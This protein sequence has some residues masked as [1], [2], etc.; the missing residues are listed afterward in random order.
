M[1]WLRRIGMRVRSIFGRHKLEAALDSELAFHMAE[2]KAEY[3]SRGMSE[4]EAERAVRLEFG[5]VTAMA[6][7]CRDQR[8]TRWLEDLTADTKYAI[9][10]LLHSPGFTWAA[11]ATL[12]LG[13]G[14]NVV[15]FS[16]AYGVL[17]RPLPYREPDRLVE[18]ELGMGGVG[19][20]TNL[21]SMAQ[22]ADYAGYSP[23]IE[24][25][26]RQNGEALRVET[27]T[28]TWNLSR[29]LGVP[30][31]LGRWFEPGEEH[32]NSPR[33][34]VLSDHTW[35]ERFA[36]DPAIIGRQ[37]LIDE[38]PHDVVGVMPPGFAFP[39]RE[40]AMWLPIRIDPA[41]RALMWSGP[42]LL[43]I[44]RLNQGVSLPSAQTELRLIVDRVRPLFPWRMPD[45][46][47]TSSTLVLHSQALVKDARP[48]LL[49]LAMA[50]FL[51]LIIACGN[52]ANLLLTRCVLRARE[53]AVR[54]ALGAGRGRLLR[55][56]AAENMVLVAAGAAAGL[57]ISLVL[58][59]ALPLALGQLPRLDEVTVAPVAAAAA[60]GI[61]LLT[62]A[63]LSV[64]P[65][66]RRRPSSR[67]SLVLAVFQLSLTTALLIG[68]SLLGRTLWQLASVDTGIHSHEILAASVSAG[69]SRCSSVE[70]CVAFLEEVSSTLVGVPGIHGVSWSNGIPLTQKHSAMSVAVQ[71]HPK[72][73]GEPAF[74]LWH[75]AATPGYFGALGIP[76]RAGRFFTA[77][78]RAGG[79]PVVVIS[80]S[81]AKKFWPNESPIGKSIRPVSG[82]VWRTVIGVA[83]DVMH[84]S[85]DG[86]PSWID[87]VQYVPH[88]Q[89]PP[90]SSSAFQQSVFLECAGIDA[91]LLQQSLRQRFPDVAITGL[92][93]LQGV[94]AASV[95][96]RRSTAWLMSLLAALALFLGIVGVY[97]TLSQRAEQRRPE[98][99]IRMALGARPI[100]IGGVVLRE[101][102][103]V[104]LVGS[105]IGVVAALGLTRFLRTLLFGISETDPIAYVAGPA[106]LVTTA[107][108][109]AALPALRASRLDP[110]KVLRSE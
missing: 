25:T 48:K 98:V 41:N 17:L 73:P 84:Y 81:T 15:F 60:G 101:A 57:S 26:I 66:A 97:G 9:R 35:R 42:N 61:M 108:L 5:N 80:E 20:V 64:A 13:A 11:V 76:L 99:G 36:A 7:Q 40:T 32:A 82:N 59:K 22:R 43:P 91:A 69:P 110:A 96:N 56:I 94:R 50:S 6:E 95:S 100:E 3:L 16:T 1:L 62:F 19:P 54:E 74:V 21:R 79:L 34:V 71:D 72:E 29:V 38:E 2:Q 87:G 65:A 23:K 77:A 24:K 78:D 27:A 106:I 44:G 18:I 51:L 58:V 12:A 103:V 109:A 33:T 93:S 55:M 88:A 47:G 85:L 70:R 8:R 75:V 4:P 67:F 52:V 102:A 63:V 89:A 104:G 53:F 105:A 83:G 46:W 45:V 30:P 10:S 31:S 39:S 107:L 86:Y 68:A 92:K 28:A 49:A 90:V 37:L 14:V